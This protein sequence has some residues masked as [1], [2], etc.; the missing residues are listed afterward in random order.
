MNKKKIAF[1]SISSLSA[2]MLLLASSIN[3]KNVDAS[4]KRSV[5]VDDAFNSKAYAGG[6]NH[7]MWND[8]S[9]SGIK[10]SD[11]G[12]AYL[13]YSEINSGGEHILFSTMKKIENIN[14]YQFDFKYDGATNRWAGISFIKNPFKADGYYDKDAYAYEG[15]INITYSS[16]NSFSSGTLSSSFNFADILSSNAID[17]WITCRIEAI[18]SN[19]AKVNFKLQSDENFNEANEKT[20]SL[21]GGFESKYD[22]KN[23]YVGI[24]PATESG[25]INFDNFIV[26]YGDNLEIKESFDNFSFEEFT[27]F[28]FLKKDA[29]ETILC[30]IKDSSYLELV[31]AKKND[32][33]ISK[34][35]IEADS[36]I[37]EE[38]EIASLSLNVK[39]PNTANDEKVGLI[40]GLDKEGTN[41]LKNCIVYEITKDQGVL[42]KYVDGNNTLDADNNTNKFTNIKGSGSILNIKIYKSG[43]FLVYENDRL[44]TKL[45]GSALDFEKLSEYEGYFG[46]AS[47]SD[48]N[49]AIQVDNVKLVNT[50]YYVPVTKSV[51]HNFSNDFFGNKGHEDFITMDGDGGGKLAAEDGKLVFN[52]GTDG[53]FFGSAHQYDDFILDFK[54]CSI[55][56]D[57]DAKDGS[58]VATAPE[59]WIGLDLSRNTKYYGSYGRYATL[60]VQI[61]PNREYG[62]TFEPAIWSDSAISN[63]N[64]DDVN[65][66]VHKKIDIS[67]MEKIQYTNAANEGN[68]KDGDAV[69]FRF[70]SSQGN[71]KLYLKTASE[72]NYTLYYEINGLE[73]NGYFALCCTGYTFM[74][75]DDFS[76]TNT[77][78]VYV[79]ADNEAP[80]TITEKETE[81]VYDHNNPDINL[82]SEISLNR[83]VDP[84]LIALIVVSS[85]EALAIV[86]LVV[87][88]LIKGKKKHE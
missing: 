2:F 59:K 43:R 5:I 50:F 66:T 39:F 81:V 76:M 18:D 56:A 4:E 54:L 52:C 65:I 75:I 36:S 70:V 67:M 60:L 27:D 20:L 34:N 55:L 68:V 15:Q 38:A 46:L 86:G 79:C 82:D 14:Y 48:I 26:N 28:G 12:E 63:F 32:F 22:F 6:L 35:Q 23:A 40:F 29:S 73:L 16:S 57:L 33:I 3:V 47:L 84:L 78:S 44:V 30:T 25:S 21:K 88:I 61:T 72:V 74:K 83:N 62:D 64:K 77:S 51:T 41:Y 80:E 69:C 87:L 85:V 58:K 11:N 9:S 31:D 17:S 7:D 49:I 42:K 45:D 10:Q 37:I 19:N 13:N 71:L 1:L 8:R 24:T 53:T